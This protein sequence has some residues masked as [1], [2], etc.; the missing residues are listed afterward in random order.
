[1]SIANKNFNNWSDKL[2]PDVIALQEI[3]AHHTDVEQLIQIWSSEY[4]TYLYPA[5]KKGYSGTALLIRKK[6]QANIT[7]GINSKKFDTEGR[8]ITAEFDSFILLNGY[9]PNGQRD[10]ARV[11]YKLE[12]S[13]KVLQL[14]LKLKDETKK[15][16]II[17]GDFNTAHKEIDLA[18]PKSNINS[19]GFLPIE[20]EFI[21]E[22]INNKFLD[23]FRS[24]YP[25]KKDEYTWWTYRSNCRER[26]IGWRL[27]Y[28]F[29]NEEFIPKI[30]SIKHQHEILGSDHC[31]VLLELRE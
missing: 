3:K 9:F 7:L 18:N 16:I 24:F 14:A 28:F 11:E 12:F 30:K 8:L 2:K 31:P 15:D 26:N 10:H 1:M 27:D 23:V 21:D 5:E 13:K 17:T 25:E 6:H 20:R 22:L 29:V 4:N 19:T